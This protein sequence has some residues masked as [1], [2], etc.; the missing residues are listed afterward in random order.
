MQI[1]T[2][3]GYYRE[4]RSRIN[5]CSCGSSVIFDPQ[6]RIFQARNKGQTGYVY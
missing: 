5:A 3:S 1:N 4:R 2:P 6:M